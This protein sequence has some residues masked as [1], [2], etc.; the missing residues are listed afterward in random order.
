VEWA[1][2]ALATFQTLSDPQLELMRKAAGAFLVSMATGGPPRWLSLL[3][4]SGAGKTF[5]A[6]LIRKA[7]KQRDLFPNRVLEVVGDRIPING[8][9][10]VKWEIMLGEVITNRHWGRISDLCMSDFAMIDEIAGDLLPQDVATPKLVEVCERRLGKWTVFT[11]N[12]SVNEIRSRDGRI[13]SRLIRGGSV[14]VDVNVTDF[15]LRSR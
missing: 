1:R 11:S 8:M 6:D 2:A 10:R 3:G 13:A 7:A 15:N 9:M 5:I 14:V 12:K 4:S